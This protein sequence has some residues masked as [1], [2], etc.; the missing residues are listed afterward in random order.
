MLVWRFRGCHKNATE[1]GCFLETQCNLTPETMCQVRFPSHPQHA[2]MLKPPQSA[3]ECTESSII[4]TV[5]EKKEAGKI[6]H[7]DEPLKGKSVF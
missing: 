7:A 2:S 5:P 1:E 4:F 3:C 6:G